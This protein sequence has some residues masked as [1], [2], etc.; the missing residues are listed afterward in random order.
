MRNVFISAKPMRN[1]KLKKTFDDIYAEYH[2]PKYIGLDPLVC[3]RRFRDG[4][5]CEAVGL[6]AAVLAYGRVE[7]I[8]RNV[9]A[10]MGI[11]GDEPINFIMNAPYRDKLKLLDKFKHRFNDGRD[12][13]ALLE[14]IKAVTLEYGSLEG[15][16]C[17]CMKRNG[18]RFKPALTSFT[19][20]LK[21]N[22]RKYCGDNR[23]GFEYLIPSPEKGSACKR[24]ALYLRWMAREDDGI[25]LGAWKSVPAS[26]LLIPVDT[27]VAKIARGYG[28][29]KRNSA[30]WKMAEEITAVLRHFDPTDPV[31]YDFSLC[32]AG[33]VNIRS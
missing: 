15:C 3:V 33:M 30:D 16:F 25:D 13:A 19:E 23:A 5:S 31:R 28:L 21:N 32:H 14:S 24:L 7:I 10:V 4:G 11:M 9:D 29:T 8:V 26:C 2:H 18:H 12:I 20:T 17:D 1:A 27:H 6:L 22:G